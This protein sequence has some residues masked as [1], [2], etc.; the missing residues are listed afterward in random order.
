MRLI[1]SVR[2]YFSF[3]FQS[4]FFSLFQIS[5]LH[6]ILTPTTYEKSRL[7]VFRIFCYFF[8]LE[9][10][11]FVEIV[12]AI[13]SR[14]FGRIFLKMCYD[15]CDKWLKYCCRTLLI[16]NWYWFV[17]GFWTAIR[18]HLTHRE[19][20]QKF[21]QRHLM[22]SRSHLTHRELIP[23]R[24]DSSSDYIESH[25]THRELIRFTPLNAQNLTTSS[26]LT[27]RELILAYITV[28]NV[29]NTG[30]TLLIENWYR[31]IIYSVCA[32]FGRTLLIENWYGTNLTK[33]CT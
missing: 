27:H 22:V 21:F 29:L 3:P 33:V 28:D 12:W 2:T 11:S 7:I 4:T 20:I 18:S 25:L 30:R 31:L 23:L 5:Y 10:S 19:L 24:S 17:C 16:E 1:F 13:I 6:S 26:H 15:S 32:A 8:K 14:N 9:N